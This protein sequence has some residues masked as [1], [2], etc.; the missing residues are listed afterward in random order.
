MIRELLIATL[1]KLT[2]ETPDQ[3]AEMTETE[4]TQSINKVLEGMQ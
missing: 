1:A 2:G 3:Y 4:I